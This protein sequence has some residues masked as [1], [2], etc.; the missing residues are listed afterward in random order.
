MPLS[1][2]DEEEGI[3]LVLEYNHYN[4]QNRMGSVKSNKNFCSVSKYFVCTNPCRIFKD[5]LAHVAEKSCI[6]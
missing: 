3:L 1:E 6:A 5:I 2:E 4:I